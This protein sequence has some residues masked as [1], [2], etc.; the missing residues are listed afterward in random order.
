MQLL[1]SMF[2]HVVGICSAIAV[3]NHSIVIGGCFDFVRLLSMCRG[4]LAIL[5]P[6]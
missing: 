2:S 6:N 1:S 5:I 3:K 4:V